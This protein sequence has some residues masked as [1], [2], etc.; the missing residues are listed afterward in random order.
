MNIARTTVWAWPRL[1]AG[2]LLA[3]VL[4]G[5]ATRVDWANRVG[6]YTFEQAVQELGPPDKQLKLADGTLVAEW[7]M[8]RGYYTTFG[9]YPY[10]GWYYWGPVYPT[11]LNSYTP[12]AFLRLTFGSNGQLTAWKRFYR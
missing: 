3:L 4:A 9:Y 8:R 7:L 11:Y 2:L 1:L 6:H 12:D 5:C 10:P